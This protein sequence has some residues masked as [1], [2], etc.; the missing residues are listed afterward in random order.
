MS[1]LKKKAVGTSYVPAYQEQALNKQSYKKKPA[2]KKIKKEN[3]RMFVS[4][5]A[6]AF[7]LSITLLTTNIFFNGLGYQITDIKTDI[8]KLEEEN[9]KLKYK[10]SNLSSLEKIEMDAQKMGMVYPESFQYIFTDKKENPSV[11][12]NDENLQNNVK[13]DKKSFLENF[14]SYIAKKT[15]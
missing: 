9:E 15:Q 3:N 12:A 13:S 4:L 6:L 10:I 2:V 5:V 14:K 11:K 8:K 1:Y 7:L